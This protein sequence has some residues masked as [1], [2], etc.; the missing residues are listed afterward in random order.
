MGRE[1]VDA[2]RKS[3]EQDLPSKGGKI[4][5]DIEHWDVEDT[6]FWETV[7][8]R[9]ANRNLWISIP[10]LAMGFAIWMMWGMI[11]T[12]MQNLAFPSRSINS[13]P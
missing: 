2:T 12:Q 7:G 3:G 4:N 11:T 5:A 13:S 6:T 10:S 9:V 1:S 8:N